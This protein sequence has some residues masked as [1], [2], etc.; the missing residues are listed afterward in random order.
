MY[1]IFELNF[2]TLTG[3]A[4]NNVL[5][6]FASATRSLGDNVWCQLVFLCKDF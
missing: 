5:R 4:E 1:N 3:V 2:T 6:P